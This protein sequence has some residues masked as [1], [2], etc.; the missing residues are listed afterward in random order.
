MFKII[1]LCTIFCG[2]TIVNGQ[3]CNSSAVPF[4]VSDINSQVGNIKRAFGYIRYSA[5]DFIKKTADPIQSSSKI[6]YITSYKVSQLLSSLSRAELTIPLEF[7]K[8]AV[9]AYFVG[10][11]AD[12]T[13]SERVKTINE[14][15][16]ISNISNQVFTLLY[17]ASVVN[18]ASKI[19]LSASEL[20]VFMD[21]KKKVAAFPQSCVIRKIRELKAL[22]DKFVLAV[23]NSVAYT[24]NDIN[25]PPGICDY[26]IP[27]YVS[28][29]V[30]YIKT[31]CAV[32]KASTYAEANG[33]CNSNGLKLFVIDSGVTQ[34]ALFAA[35]ATVYPVLVDSAPRLFINGQSDDTSLWFTTSP[36]L[37]LFGSITWNAIYDYD[38]IRGPITT[39]PNSCLAVL[40]EQANPWGVS[41]MDCDFPSNFFCEY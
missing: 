23:A 35:I 17:D 26:I 3:S 20:N 7:I 9:K 10:V 33:T 14:V 38:W 36:Q 15:Y 8:T 24:I 31:L 22:N 29:T 12:V 37:P 4:S 34:T 19:G 6:D 13:S 5:L 11:A 41:T 28:D 1:I 30:N 32:E 25:T 18:L 39:S 2:L 40:R 21:N 27:L 16:F